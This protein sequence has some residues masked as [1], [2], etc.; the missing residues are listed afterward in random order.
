MNLRVD[1]LF[2][3][4]QKVCAEQFGFVPERILDNLHYIGPLS[5]DRHAFRDSMSLAEI[6]LTL[7]PVSATLFERPGAELD[8]SQEL[9]DSYYKT[10][11]QLDAEHA[12][13]DENIRE[14]LKS[15]LWAT[16]GA[17]IRSLIPNHPTYVHRNLEPQLGAYKLITQLLEQADPDA[18][19]FSERMGTTDVQEL[20]FY[21]LEVYQRE[22]A[23]EVWAAIKSHPNTKS[24]VKAVEENLLD[25]NKPGSQARRLASEIAEALPARFKR[26]GLESEIISLTMGNKSSL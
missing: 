6:H 16:H 8:W 24:I 13:W 9:R 4:L 5:G 22:M 2:E 18:V 23:V 19:A 15:P 26:P 17:Y 3:I 12:V 10:D 1:E 14:T 7:N 11:D 20:S 21:L 25:Y